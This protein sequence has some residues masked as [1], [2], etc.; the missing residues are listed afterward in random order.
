VNDANRPEF[1]AWLRQTFS[2]ML[3]QL[4]Y[5][6]QPSNSPTDR[7]KHSILFEML[8]NVAN[9]P[10]VVQQTQTLVQQYMKDPQSI[11]GTL[12]GAVVSVAARHGALSS[13]L[14][15]RSSSRTRSRPNSTTSISTLWG[16][17]PQPELIKGTLDASLT[18]EVRVQDLSCWHA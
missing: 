5:S 18:P 1:L 11:D 7:Q 2:P 10:Q 13:T 8:G 14:N 4:G 6:A 9:D 16:E 17:F 3:Q 12:S 15:L